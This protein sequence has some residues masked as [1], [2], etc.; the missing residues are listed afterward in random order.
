VI[1]A[2]AEYK[3][4]IFLPFLDSIQQNILINT[5]KE[6]IAISKSAD[7]KDTT[8]LIHTGT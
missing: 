8:K 7:E 1:C 5:G 2:Q 3:L 4:Q 6:K